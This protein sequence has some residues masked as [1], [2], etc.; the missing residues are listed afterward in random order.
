MDDEKKPVLPTLLQILAGIFMC[1]AVFMAFKALTDYD[2][3]AELAAGI[4]VL[5]GSFISAFCWSLAVIVKAATK[6]MNNGQ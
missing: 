3:G 1:I 5:S 6:Y 4:Y 2:K